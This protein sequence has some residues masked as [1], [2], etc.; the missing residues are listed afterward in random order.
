MPAHGKQSY[1]VKIVCDDCTHEQIFD[2]SAFST[3]CPFRFFF[4]IAQVFSRFK[5]EIIPD[6]KFLKRCAEENLVVNKR[7]DKVF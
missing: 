4:P 5:V 1:A 3:F 6:A 7:D 2:R